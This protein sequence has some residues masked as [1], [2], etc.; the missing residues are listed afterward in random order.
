MTA[1]LAQGYKYKEIGDYGVGT[2][3]VVTMPEAQS[4]ICSAEEFVEC[5]AAILA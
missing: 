2:D 4:A 5:V 3:A 1:F